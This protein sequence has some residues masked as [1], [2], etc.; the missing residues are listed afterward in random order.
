MSPIQNLLSREELDHLADVIAESELKTSGEIRLM[1]VGRSSRSSH[2]FPLIACFLSTLL[3]VAIWYE[4]EWILLSGH[5]WW[6][7]SALW[8][9][10]IAAWVLSRFQFIQRTLT[11]PADLEHQVAMRAEIE[12]HREGLSRTAGS[13]G[14]LIFLSVMERQAV[15]LADKG[16]A[17]KLDKKIWLEVVNLVIEGARSNK[18][19]SKLEE[20][21]RRCGNLLSAHFP[22]QPGD[23]NELSNTVIVKE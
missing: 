9:S 7:V 16:I 15:V 21:V 4:R 11:S 3:I 8:F 17:E 12:F 14:I 5:N 1:I 23:V 19:A 20:A 13:T 2:V 6:V 10:A 22:I 18:L